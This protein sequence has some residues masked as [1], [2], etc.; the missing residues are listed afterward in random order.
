MKM[1][2]A[3]VR[4]L[5]TAVALLA[6]A[7]A[8][9]AQDDERFSIDRDATGTQ[10]PIPIAL[11]GYSGEAATV[12]KFD[13]YV[14]GFKIVGASESPQYELKGAN[15]GQVEGKLTDAINKS[16]KFAKAFSGG[17]TR[18]QAHALAN[19][20]IEAVTGARGV[21]G[22]KVAFKVKTG[23][24][25][26]AGEIYVA[27]CDGYNATAVT[28][29]GA[30]VASPSWVPGRRALFY[31]TYKFG[32]PDIVLHDLNTGA[33]SVVARYGGSNISPAA[34]PDGRQVAMILSKGGSPDL[35]VAN[36]DG[37]GLRQL[38]RTKEDESSPCWS[39]DG[40]WICFATRMDGRRV[41]AKVP[42]AGGPIQRLT[43]N[44]GSNPTEP[45]WSPDGKQ[46][47]FTSQAGKFF[48][49]CVVP[50]QGGDARILVEGKDP[51]WAPNSRTLIFNH[52]V[53]GRQ[54]LSLLD[55][56]TKQNKDVPQTVGDSSQPS[57][58]K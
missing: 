36:A 6:L 11:A 25:G 50:A 28:H 55:V 22:T 21:A 13:L 54:V 17:T 4:P 2:L 19:A 5:L 14:S 41:L 44:L 43:A 34:S 7:A 53:G 24:A 32:N 3:L 1:S 48:R 47:A 42:A 15:N 20:V 29:D 57:W 52:A 38:T 30:I 23:A 46:I 49:I 18:S 16:V 31:N 58:A 26:G 51:A 8:L 56:P 12:L 33:R 39:P 9:R 35:Y 40:R 45:D 10:P 27:D 37:S